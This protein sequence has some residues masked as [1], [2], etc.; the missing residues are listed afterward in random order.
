VSFSSIAY[1]AGWV[2]GGIARVDALIEG[3]VDY[4]R[5][6]AFNEITGEVL[7]YPDSH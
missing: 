6:R 5:V 7:Y 2:Y 3:I 1:P 4:Q